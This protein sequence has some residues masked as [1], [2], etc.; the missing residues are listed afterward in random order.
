MRK[1]I[2]HISL[3]TII[4]STLLFF[5]SC[6]K[7][8]KI[9]PI[10]TQID[11]TAIKDSLKALEKPK[12]IIHYSF[13]PIEG[14]KTI[15]Y[16]TEKYGAEG[17]KLILALNR[18]DVRNLH[19]KDS[20]IIP[21]TLLNNILP[22]SPFPEKLNSAKQIKKL[23]FFSYPTQAFAAYEFGNL[24]RWGPTSMGK[25]STQTPVGLYYTN[26][27]SKSTI[28]TEDSSWILP[29]YFNLENKS[30][31]S[32]HQ[33]ALPGY[34]ASHACARLL[35]TD[36]EWFYYW[37]E[38]WIITKDGEDVLAYGTPVIIFGEYNFKNKI[39]PWKMLAENPDT[40]NINEEEL[41]KLVKKFLPDIIKKA[42]ARD[43]LINARDEIKKDTLNI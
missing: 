19:N 32:I 26:W 14:R 43:S 3:F 25:K 38:Q 36:A 30:G 5:L 21:D 22:Y 34:P 16:L 20:L 2:L 13:I 10:Q 18:L 40:N 23:F 35:D 31:V 42:E 17:R 7:P 29:W 9:P 11:S 1:I 39:Q 6:N 15:K 12:L 37:A 33:F 4:S 8:E 41:N 24:V 27:K 28:S